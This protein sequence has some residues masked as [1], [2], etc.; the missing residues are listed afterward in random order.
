MHITV[1]TPIVEIVYDRG[2]YS[3]LCTY[4]T[5]AEDSCLMELAHKKTNKIIDM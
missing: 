3:G 5:A 1:D 4:L 2:S